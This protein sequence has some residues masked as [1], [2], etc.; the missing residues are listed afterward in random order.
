MIKQVLISC[1]LT[2]IKV[3]DR[4]IKP[5]HN[6]RLKKY[7][8]LLSWQ[9]KA[10]TDLPVKM[11]AWNPAAFS[12][13]EFYRLCGQPYLNEKSWINVYDADISGNQQLIDYY[14]KL[15][16]DSLVIYIEMSETQKKL[17]DELH[18][19]YIDI[20]VHPVRYMSDHFFLLSTNDP[21]IFTRLKEYELDERQFFLGAQL[22]RTQIDQDPFIAEKNSGLLVGQT[23]LDRSLIFKDKLY[24]LGNYLQKIAGIAQKCEVLYFKPHP[25]VKDKALYEKLRQVENL[26]FTNENVYKILC[27]D[28]VNLVCG[29]SSSV[30]YEA[31]YFN[32]RVQFFNKKFD[33]Y[34]DRFSERNYVSIGNDILQPSFWQQ[35]ILD[36]SDKP[37][38]DIH[39]DSNY[40]RATL[41]DFWSFTQYDPIVR[42]V[43]KADLFS[44]EKATGKKNADSVKTNQ[45]LAGSAVRIADALGLRFMAEAI[46]FKALQLKLEKEQQKAPL[47]YRSLHFITYRPEA[48]Q[49]GRGGAGAVQ[50]AVKQILGGRIADLPVKYSFSER[51][52]IW[53]T[54]KNKYFVKKRFPVIYSEESRLFQLWATMVFAFDKAKANDCLY[55]TQDVPTGYALALMKRDFILVIHSQGSRL[56]EIDALGEK[57]ST[58]E[59]H[60]INYMEDQAL[61]S[62]KQVYFPSLGAK[63][64]F[65]HSKYKRRGL[66]SK[67]KFAATPLY[68]TLYY[69][70]KM[71]PLEDI[72][73]NEQVITCISVGTVTASKGQD[74]SLAYLI[75]AAAS[76]PD[77]SFRWICVGK[78]PLLDKLKAEDKHT[79]SNLEVIFMQKVPYPQVQYLLSISD[80]YIML[81]R[82]SIFDLATLEAMNNSCML[83]LSRQGG[84]LEF[85]PDANV[86]FA[87]VDFSFAKADIERLKALNKA[88]YKKYFSNDK[89]KELWS[90]TVA[91][92]VSD[93]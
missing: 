42:V 40:I 58:Y 65:L 6:V 8:D 19:P 5:F 4:K 57:F 18:I 9:I 55:I 46:R 15:I 79:P 1:D 67:V 16:A 25:Y 82:K 49:G 44:K 17:H 20:S 61:L 11:L 27:S 36:K 84:N 26:K 45:G 10:G 87:D 43:K 91:A 21:R 62:A 37:L 52:G 32:K 35:V 75:K 71:Q 78:G 69:V 51:D 86:V 68:N 14:C 93:K 77:L 50:T 41:N 85:N 73:P 34:Q 80:I 60:I 23:F 22:L 72:Q 13:K 39:L 33:M 83:I 28:G 7:F 29:I 48:P 54:K 53:H 64:E 12:Q 31:K 76:H 81:H 66:L 30:L 59:R 88:A 2:R 56:D 24:G 92:E 63:S 90:S 89:F 3:E 74:N 38:I 47:Q 70:P